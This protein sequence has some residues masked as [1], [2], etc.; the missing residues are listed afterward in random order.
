MNQCIS[1]RLFASNLPFTATEKDL[2]DHFA[3]AGFV[4]VVNIWRD[5][6]TGRSRGLAYIEILCQEQRYE[7][8]GGVPSHFAFAEAWSQE[9]EDKAIKTFDSRNFMGRPLRLRKKA[10][11]GRMHPDNGLFKANPVWDNTFSIMYPV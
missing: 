11:A 5:P 10:G 6:A 4:V 3:K 1:T 2:R 7:L 8:S 9:Q